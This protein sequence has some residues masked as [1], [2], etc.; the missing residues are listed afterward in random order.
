[1]NMDD[2]SLSDNVMLDVLYQVFFMGA[3][4]GRGEDA[5]LLHIGEDSEPPKPPKPGVGFPF[6]LPFFL[7]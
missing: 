7:K 1:M 4:R 5:A 2:L 6:V 3:F